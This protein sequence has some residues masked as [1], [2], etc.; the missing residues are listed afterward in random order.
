MRQTKRAL[1]ILAL[2]LASC[3]SQFV[4]AS[5]PTSGVATLRVY[6]T[7]AALPLL[8]DLIFYYSRANPTIT[9]DV[10][11][12]NYQVMLERLMQGGAPFL[13]TNHLASESLWAAPLGQ[14][15]IAVIVHPSNPISGLTTEQ[16]RRIY[17]GHVG[18]WRDVDGPDM[19]VVVVSRED[20]SGTRAEFERLVMGA[21]RTA[22]SA[23]IA[24]SSAA[25]VASV[26]RQPGSIGYVSMSYV[27][28]TVRAALVDGVELTPDTVYHNIYPL[29]STLYIAGLNEPQDYYLN[30]IAWIQSQ[31]GQMVVGQRYAPLLRP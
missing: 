2:T 6:A 28:E 16:L 15:G 10:E 19:E 27:D 12:G 22:R 4:P 1:A 18:N 20:G 30:F 17:Q 21:R 5:T 29:R 9:F 23:Q 8:N 7:G 26:S 14:D 3:S 11:S 13:L 24:P 25:M 31:E